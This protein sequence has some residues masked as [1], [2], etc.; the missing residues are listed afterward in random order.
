[1]VKFYLEKRRNTFKKSG[2][3]YAFNVY[4]EKGNYSWTL[5]TYDEKPSKKEVDKITSIFLRAWDIY[6]SGFNPI[7]N[8]AFEN[9]KTSLREQE[10]SGLTKE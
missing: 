3:E 9:F 6:S 4:L 5:I 2:F 8:L 10:Y 7:I 1:M